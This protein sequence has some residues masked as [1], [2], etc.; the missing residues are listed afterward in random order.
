MDPFGADA[1]LPRQVTF[2]AHTE[3]GKM[4]QGWNELTAH[5]EKE[6]NEETK[7]DRRKEKTGDRF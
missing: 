5:Q 4:G 2:S 3:Q 6:K 1:A 7:K